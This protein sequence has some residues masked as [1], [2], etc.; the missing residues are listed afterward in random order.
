MHTKQI[1]VSYHN[2][3]ITGN[4]YSWNVV[5]PV[6]KKVCAHLPGSK[7]FCALVTKDQGEKVQQI[8]T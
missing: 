7:V 1:W 8:L 2:T 6:I 5:W 3:L 4:R